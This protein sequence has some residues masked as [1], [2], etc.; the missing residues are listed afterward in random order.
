MSAS[1][2]IT[3]KEDLSKATN[4]TYWLKPFKTLLKDEIEVEE[5]WLAQFDLK[6]I[7]KYGKVY[8]GS[9]KLRDLK[10]AEASG[11]T[12]LITRKRVRLVVADIDLYF[13]ERRKFFFNKPENEGMELVDFYDFEIERCKIWIA[14]YPLERIID[15]CLKHLEFEKATSNSP[16]KSSSNSSSPALDLDVKGE[17]QI[18]R[19]P[20]LTTKQIVEKHIKCFAGKKNSIKLLSDADY[21]KLIAYTVDLIERK[22]V[23][24][25]KKPIGKFAV[26]NGFL[27]KTFYNLHQEINPTPRILN[28]WPVFLKLCFEQLKENES[29]KAKWSQ[30]KASAYKSELELIEY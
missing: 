29:I 1:Y 18:D 4:Y 14:A 13:Q 6:H 22:K 10:K 26:T 17:V 15:R 3:E 16:Q 30:M 7:G 9:D 25:I 12:E 21:N 28:D 8:D 5:K 11:Q 20:E 24:K 2:S 27:L 23:P 19:E